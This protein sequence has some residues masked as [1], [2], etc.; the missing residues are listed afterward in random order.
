MTIARMEWIFS[1]KRAWCIHLPT[2]NSFL[3]LSA[4]VPLTYN[5]SEAPLPPT[6]DDL[7]LYMLYEE[8]VNVLLP[9]EHSLASLITSEP[10][11]STLRNLTK[12]LREGDGELYQHSLD[13]FQVVS[14]FVN[15]LQIP[16]ELS[17]SIRLAALFH[18]LGKLA[19]PSSILQK[20]GCLTLQE[21]EQV[22]RHAAY[23][24]QQLQELLSL[25]QVAMMVY[26]HHERWDGCGYP[27]TLSGLMIPLGSRIIA[28]ADA[29]VVMTS[30]RS[31]R[32]PCSPAEALNELIACSGTQF[33]PLLVK[34]FHAGLAPL[35]EPVL[36]NAAAKILY[37]S[38][39]VCYS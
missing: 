24:A 22:K 3:A 12:Q 1:R 11:L 19:I 29:Y 39:K 34:L 2:A 35:P 17:I 13:V 26:H 37:S 38:S 36:D 6:N 5:T 20:P 14:H 32:V 7:S 8:A 4:R 33:D 28:I 30:H 21:R 10:L 15:L 18:D 16:R 25:R 31:Y 27:T 9:Q 23:G